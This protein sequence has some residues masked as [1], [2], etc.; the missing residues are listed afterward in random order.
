MKDVPEGRVRGF[1]MRDGAS[2]AYRHWDVGE[3]HGAVV[4]IHG[5]FD[6]HSGQGVKQPLSKII[7]DFRFILIK[8]CGHHPWLERQ[9][10]NK[11]YDVLRKE[12]E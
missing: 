9:A 6:P 3:A 10:Q 5:D 12:L 4:A 8:N 7:K 1:T 2:L 11:F